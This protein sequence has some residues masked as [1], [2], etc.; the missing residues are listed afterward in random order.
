MGVKTRAGRVFAPPLGSVARGVR[1]RT[2]QMNGH[3]HRP[4]ELR[5]RDRTRLTD[6]LAFFNGDVSLD[7]PTHYG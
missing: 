1:Q 2:S 5:L 6:R 3:P 4:R 7:E